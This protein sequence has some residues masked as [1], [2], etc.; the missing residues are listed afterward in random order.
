MSVK[1]LAQTGVDIQPWQPQNFGHRQKVVMP[2]Q[3]FTEGVHLKKIPPIF[4][5]LTGE[6]KTIKELLAAE[7]HE[8]GVDGL[9]DIEQKPAQQTMASAMHDPNSSDT[10]DPSPVELMTHVKQALTETIHAEKEAQYAEQLA[11]ALA[12][13]AAQLTQAHELALQTLQENLQAAHRQEIETLKQ[14]QEEIQYQTALQEAIASH[15][16][17]HWIPLLQPLTEQITHAE[18]TLAQE[19]LKLALQCTKYIVRA[20]IDTNPAVIAHV[21]EEILTIAQGFKQLVLMLNSTD[22]ELLMQEDTEQQPISKSLRHVQ[23]QLQQLGCQVVSHD[24]IER[25]GCQLR[26]SGGILD[27]TLAYRWDTLYAMLGVSHAG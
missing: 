16:E 13:Q 19:V 4:P 5:W 10:P 15:I 27:A 3:V 1:E 14:Q 24:D 22:Y 6:A 21:I 17:Q 23:N 18:H 12:E 11:A 2:T 20:E 7:L 8:D 26:H 9:N 25:G